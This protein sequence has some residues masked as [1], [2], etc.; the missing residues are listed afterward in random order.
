MEQDNE[1]SQEESV[2]NFLTLPTELLV[3]I[4]SFLSS[5][6]D[7][8]KLRYVSSWLKCVIEGTPSLWKEFVWPYYDVRDECRVKEVLKVCGQHIKVL[9][10]PNSRVPSTLVE[11]MQHCSNVQHLYLGSAKLDSEQIGKIIH[12]HMR[13]LQTL[14]IKI[15][16]YKHIIYF[17]AYIGELREFTIFS[18]PYH[19]YALEELFKFWVGT[20]L[21]P[22]NFNF[23]SQISNVEIERLIDC[24]AHLSTI[25][26]STANFRVFNRYD[27]V[28]LNFSPTL[29]C[30]QLQFEAS[31]QVKIP[32]VKLSDFGILGL[33]ND[34]VV[35]TDCQYGE[36]K[37][38]M[39]KYDNVL[40][41]L[42]CSI[43]IT[44]HVNLSYATHFNF[45]NCFL[46]RSGHLEQLA[47]A[48]PNLQ[49]L[50]LQDCFHCLESL[51]GLRTVST[52]CRNLQG[53]NLLGI[54]VSLMED[55]IQFWEILSDMK[56]NHLALQ[57]CA[58]KSD[59]VRMGRFICLYQKCLTIQGIQCSDCCSN[60]EDILML[61]YFPSLQYC[62]IQ[63]Y[64]LPNIV[65]DVIMNCKKLR[66][67]YFKTD[68]L[69]LN[70]MICNHNLQQLCI[71]SPYTDVPDDFMTSVSAHGGLVHV[72]M[73]VKSLTEKGVTFLVKNSLQLITLYLQVTFINMYVEY[74]NATL[75][76]MFWNRRLVT[77]GFYKLD[78]SGDV[79]LY[80]RYPLLF[81]HENVLREQGTD[82]LPLWDQL[83]F[84]V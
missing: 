70:T 52:H 40:N 8:V 64:G 78:A 84:N 54:L 43:C 41:K 77:T 35:M 66:C 22:S 5:T 10:F 27:R 9:S 2:V 49:R 80:P 24:A 33:K 6:H 3:Y 34:V 37:M 29:P 55:H 4:I 76:K 39:V 63:Y 83:Y 19:Y 72:V 17:L 65:K 23:N 7:K 25:P 30:F 62:H 20:Q 44:S 75:R 12:I 73:R 79:N 61:S 1:N 59:A 60:D 45:K 26:S 16:D 48:C 69:L 67:A 18:R 56:L 71:D 15:D 51:Q 28:P 36:R 68:T 13:Y 82:L 46:L 81:E 32:A 47:I 38:Y 50:N 31:V 14:E 11:M 53:L 74:F 57:H 58:L 42:K 21:R